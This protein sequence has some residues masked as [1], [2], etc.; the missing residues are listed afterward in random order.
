[1]IRV[2]DVYTCFLVV[3][4]NILLRCM[5]SVFHISHL[6]NIWYNIRGSLGTE[7]GVETEEQKAVTILAEKERDS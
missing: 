7:V 6:N 3:C 2:I 5:Y 4:I 1:M